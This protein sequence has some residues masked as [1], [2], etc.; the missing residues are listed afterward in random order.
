VV[1]R[2][3][4]PNPV[5]QGHHASTTLRGSALREHRQAA[6][7]AAV[8]VVDPRG[9]AVL[10]PGETEVADAGAV[11]AS[12][13]ADEGQ[14]V[15]TRCAV[16]VWTLVLI[17]VSFG[18][19]AASPVRLQ[20]DS[21][22]VVFT[23]RS[24][25]AHGDVDLDEYRSISDHGA[26]FQIEQQGR[27]AYYEAPLGTSLAAVP[28]VAVASLIDGPG[29]DQQ[30]EQGRSQPLDG[31]IA[32]AMAAIT[33]GLMFLVMLGLTSR[34]WIALATTAVFA[35]GTQVWSTASRTLW[36][37]TPSLM[38]L[39][40]ALLVAQRARR[41]GAWCYTLGTVMALA[42]F[43][44]PTNVVPLLAFAIW[45]AFLG[46]RPFTRFA[47]GGATVGCT[48][49]ILDLALYGRVLQP[50][51]RASRVSLAATTVE[52]LAGNLFSPSRGLIMF[53]PVSLLCAYGFVL[54]RHAGTLSSLDVTIAG[55]AVGYWL[56]VSLFPTWYA[57][58]SY[59]PRFLTDIAPM[60]VWFLPPVLESVV[61][62]RRVAL[63]VVVSIAFVASVAIQA[64]GSIEQSTADWN[65]TPHSIDVD[66]ARLWDFEDL[67]FLR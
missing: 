39:T 19:Y 15:A 9:V 20:T 53:V 35:F 38:C 11:P 3:V 33:V 21:H 17:I 32:A 48:F 44:R 28:F 67:Q 50:Y 25:V 61:I 63:G 23:A 57:G 42:Y 65:W 10:I 16:V 49:I 8:P 29:L 26:T 41:S 18:L 40:L 56:L 27:H 5:H 1:L 64:R 4:R 2:L 6:L 45:I 36:M 66:Q 51:F 52:A 12:V 46:R 14:T 43:V 7:K 59:G 55:G 60:L 22:W 24:L 30:L 34:L 58:W 31:W 13:E 37:H 62:R 47:C 54:K